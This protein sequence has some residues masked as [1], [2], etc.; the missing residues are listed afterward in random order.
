MSVPDILDY[1]G[2]VIEFDVMYGDPSYFVLLSQNCYDYLGSFMVPH[3]VLKC[4][5]C[6]CEI[7]H[8]YFNRDCIESI[9]CLE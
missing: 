3:K 6:I 2:L 4:L 1:H 5:F 7:C 9:N 8:G